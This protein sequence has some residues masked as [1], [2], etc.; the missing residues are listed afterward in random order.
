MKPLAPLRSTSATELRGVAARGEHDG[1]RA[2]VRGQRLGHAEPVYVRQLDVQQDD[3][4]P[5]PA[6]KLDRARPILGHADDLESLGL[7]QRS[8]R[9]PEAWVVVDDE[10]G[11]R[12]VTNGVSR[13]AFL[14]YG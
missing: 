6:R 1:G 4:G 9:H 11:G 2:A 10:D 5:E 14:P 7:Q 12:H 8:R 13:S 3:F